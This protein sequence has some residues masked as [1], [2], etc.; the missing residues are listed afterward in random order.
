MSYYNSGH[1]R[2]VLKSGSSDNTRSN[3]AYTIASDDNHSGCFIVKYVD[4]N[5]SEWKMLV[6][7]GDTTPIPTHA[8]GQDPYSEVNTWGTSH[9]SIKYRQVSQS[10]SDFPDYPITTTSTTTTLGLPVRNGQ[11]H[12]GGHT[13]GQWFY[14]TSLPIFTITDGDFTKVNRYITDGDDSGA[15]NYEDLHP[16]SFETK[17]FFDGMFP[18]LYYKTTRLTGELAPD[19]KCEIQTNFVEPQ[20]TPITQYQQVYEIDDMQFIQYGNY[21]NPTYNRYLMVFSRQD[22][23]QDSEWLKWVASIDFAVNSDT[24]EVIIMNVYDSMN[25]QH[26]ISYEFGTPSD[27]DYPTDSDNMNHDPATND[28]SGANTLTKTYALNDVKLR[29]LGNFLWSSTFK[30]NILDVANNPLENV[31]SIKAMPLTSGNYTVVASENI[32]IGNVDTGI[33]ADNVSKSDKIIIE[34]GNG[35]TMVRDVFKNFIDYTNLTIQIYLPFI[36]VKTLDNLVYL[37]RYIRVRYIYDCILGNVLAEISVKG[38]N[39]NWILTDTYQANCGVDISISSTNRAEIEH[40]FINSAIS[41]VSNLVSGNP[42][43]AVADAYNGMTQQFHSESTGVGNPS[44]MGA[45]DM[46]CFLIIKRPKFF[47]PQK[48]STG[49]DIYGHTIGYPCNLTKKLKT[50]KINSVGNNIKGCFFSVK[51]FNGSTIPQATEQEKQELK[52]L[53]ESGVILYDR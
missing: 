42:L 12:E 40:G 21:A 36:G 37:N 27:E 1:I 19:L 22:I 53:L 18:S 29:A 13:S 6:A 41:A 39:G 51:N 3:Y 48:T 15:D 33:V 24:G 9:S 25:G 50:L 32:Q 2:C 52:E 46:K 38:N 30:Q 20:A 10:G 28:L 16:L 14:D 5:N 4:P 26:T 31:V 7:C 11:W 43:G 23:Y 44:L 47:E 34:V 49:L 35:K 45:L 17:I 8:Q